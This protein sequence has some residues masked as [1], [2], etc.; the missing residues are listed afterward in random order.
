MPEGLGIGEVGKE[1]AEH[2]KAETEQAPDDQDRASRILTI[3]EAVLLATVAVLAAYSGFAAA[4]WSTD[5]SLHLAQASTTRNLASRAQLAGL[6]T[7]NFDGLTFNAWFTAYD[8]GNKTAMAVA[9]RRFRPEF[10]VAFKAWLATKPFSNPHAPPGP[11]YMPEYVHPDQAKADAL[12]AKADELY[13][14]GAKAGNTADDY[15]RTTVL[16]ASVLFLVGIAGH[17]RVRAARVGLIGVGAGI[18][19]LSAILVALSPAPHI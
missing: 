17:F 18:L 10:D 15:V 9:E 16:L 13:H 12:D 1:I 7:K 11:T 8:S 19:V 14:E 4:K 5:S 3:C 2:K 6:Q